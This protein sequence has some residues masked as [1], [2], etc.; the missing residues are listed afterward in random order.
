MTPRS[1]GHRPAVSQHPFHIGQGQRRVGLDDPLRAV[2]ILHEI[3]DR[4][5]RDARTLD[6]QPIALD[7]AMPIGLADVFWPSPGERPS[8]LLDA[9]GDGLQL[10]RDGGLAR[11]SREAFPS[12]AA[13]R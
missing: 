13:S 3:G 7:G 5:D 4:L 8:G 2:A 6:E 11:P 1:S 10:D 12:W 9:S